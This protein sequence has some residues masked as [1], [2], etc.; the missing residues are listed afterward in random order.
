MEFKQWLSD[1]APLLVRQ[2]DY[3]TYQGEICVDVILRFERLRRDF[4]A[5]CKRIGA[6]IV[7]PHLN[8]SSHEY[9]TYY[10]DQETIDLVYKVYHWD[11]DTFG[12]KH[13]IKH[14]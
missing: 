9:Y 14:L 4:A 12:Y 7:L 3:L 13:S 2:K 1:A 8:R 6:N 11:V 10:Y 5:L